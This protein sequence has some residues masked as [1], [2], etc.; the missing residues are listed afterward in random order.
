[1][2]SLYNYADV[3]ILTCLAQNRFNTLRQKSGQIEPK[4]FSSTCTF[5]GNAMLRYSK[6]TINKSP[7]LRCLEAFEKTI[8]GGYSST[9]IRI[10]FNTSL[11]GNDGIDIHLPDENKKL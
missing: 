4:A 3:I 5:T 6:I 10:S 7:N 8:V 1:M 9:P 11:I 2:V